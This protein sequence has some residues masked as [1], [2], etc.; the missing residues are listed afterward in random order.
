METAMPRFSPEDVERFID[1]LRADDA[2]RSRVEQAILSDRLV[3]LPDTVDVGLRRMED[4]LGALAES[5]KTLAEAVDSRLSTLENAVAETNR[6][7]NWLVQD[8][9]PRML[10]IVSKI[11]DD[12]E[13]VKGDVE[14][15]KGDVMA[16]KVDVALLNDRMRIVERHLGLAS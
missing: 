8:G 12:V 3:R 14:Q 2:L 15:V 4:A 10:G 6:N 1:A 11:G 5:V 16:V 13:Q 9:F 7:M